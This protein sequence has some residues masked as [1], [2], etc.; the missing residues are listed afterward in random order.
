MNHQDNHTED[1]KIPHHDALRSVD[2]FKVPTFYFDYLPDRI[3]KRVETEAVPSELKEKVFQ[4]PVGYFESFTDRVMNR[5]QIH[6]AKKTIQTRFSRSW[7]LSVAAMVVIA[8]SFFLFTL[9]NNQ[10]PVDYLANSSEEELL[11]YV[12][13]ND[14]DFDQNSLAM[15]MNEEDVNSLNI[16]DD[17][18]DETT[19]M[20]IELYK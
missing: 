8:V 1:P 15:L 16:M 11:E 4:V 10:K 7:M 6:P 5:I 17:M 13:V 19:N 18:D 12:S 2:S 3:M 14:S 20:L 9:Y